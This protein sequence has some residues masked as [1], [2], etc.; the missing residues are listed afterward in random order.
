[1]ASQLEDW[2]EKQTKRLGKALGMK[3]EESD[4]EEQELEKKKI[5]R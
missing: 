4:E 3:V 5:R 1:M 2:V